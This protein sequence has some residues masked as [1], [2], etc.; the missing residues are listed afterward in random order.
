MTRKELFTMIAVS[1]GSFMVTLDISIV[2]VALPAIQQ[3]LN[4]SMTDL[5]W[6]VDAYA[7]TLSAL[8]LS[9]GIMSDRFGKKQIWNIGVII[10]TIGSIIC[11]LSQNNLWLI[12]GRIT[13]GIGG[14]ALIPGAMAIIMMTFTDHHMRN[15]M[16]GIWSSS[17]A[18]A[19]IVGPMMGGI[20]VNYLGWSTIFSINIPIGLL[21]IILSTYAIRPEP[22]NPN[23]SL[24]PLGQLLTMIML[25]TLTFGLIELSQS[26]SLLFLLTIFAISLIA[27][28]LFIL[29]ESKVTTPLVPL[30]L[31]KSWEFSRNNIASFVIGFAT[32]SN[33]FFL[34]LFFQN[35]QGYSAIETGFRLAPEFIAMGLFAMGYGKIAKHIKVQTLLLVA[36]VL[37]VIS[38]LIMAQFTPHSHYSIIAVSMFLMGIGM[39]ISIP[40][41]SLLT[42]KDAPKDKIGSV[43]S[44]MNAFRQTGMAIS[45]ALLGA[46]M[47]SSAIKALQS[48]FPNHKN[49]VDDAITQG[50]ISVD[51]SIN[52]IQSAWAYGFNIA[53]FGA[54][55]SAMIVII[56]L[57]IKPTQTT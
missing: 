54:A 22:K 14:A 38:A 36:F 20:L 25:G 30:S 51:I 7:L 56:C 50:I 4:S 1:L 49:I 55:I 29:W 32:Y 23:I 34:S 31:F 10:F 46:I 3:D 28:I 26:P 18:I 33:I 16:V 47:T 17:T 52:H 35:A 5:Q 2:N 37:I 53:M 21:I 15:K 42:L 6:I 13:Q 41:V 48:S 19:L 9:S 45:I 43:S 12:I 57:F 24:D 8:I 27:F 40:A 44:I 11:A 39:G